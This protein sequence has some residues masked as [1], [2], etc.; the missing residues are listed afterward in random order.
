M[1]KGKIKEGEEGKN[2]YKKGNLQLEREKDI[3]KQENYK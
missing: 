2:N 1:M 3:W